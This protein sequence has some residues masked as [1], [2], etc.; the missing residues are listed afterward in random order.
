MKFLDVLTY[1]ECNGSDNRWSPVPH[2][3]ITQTNADLLST[4][5]RG[6]GYSEI[7]IKM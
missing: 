2:Q 7:A 3:A 1:A 6:T 5:I 4:G